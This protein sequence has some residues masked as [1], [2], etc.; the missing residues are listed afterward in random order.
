MDPAIPIAACRAGALGVVDLELATSMAAIAGVLA[1]TAEAAPAP[2][3]VRLAGYEPEL[4]AAIVADLPDAAATVIFSSGYGADLVDLLQRLKAAGKRVLLEV[5]S[6]SQATT[7]AGWGVD[8]L[9]AKGGEAGGWGSEETAFVLLQRLRRVGLPVFAQGGIGLHSVT[10]CLVAGAAGVVLDSQLL[11]TRES[12]LSRSVKQLIARLDGT[13]TVRVGGTLG[14]PCR[15]YLHV[16]CDP[17]ESLLSAERELLGIDID[18]S[19][20][21]LQWRREV[22]RHCGWEAPEKCAWMV[23]QDVAFAKSLGDRFV[24]VGGVIA[25]L[26]GAIEQHVAAVRAAYPLAEGATLAAIHGTRYPIVQGPMTRVSDRAQFALD[27]AD[28]GALPFLALALMRGDEAE[29]LLAETQALLG[30]R[31]WGVGILGF[32]PPELRK[33]QLDAI[34]GY[35]PR[36]A[37]IAGGRPDQAQALERDGIATYLHVPSTGLLRL[38]VRQGARSFVFEGHEC[39]G[40]V[41]PLS[42]FVLWNSM[43]ELLMSELP[44]NDLADCRILFAGGIHDSVSAAMVAA[45]ASP[46]AAKG[47]AIGVLMGTAYLYTREAVSSGAILQGF[48]DQAIHCSHTVLL[49]SGP[50]HATR[51]AD[52]EFART[53]QLEKQRLLREGQSAEE[54]R[55][56]LEGMNIGRLRVASK[57]IDR[58]PSYQPGSDLAKFVELEQSEQIARGMYMIGQV[59]V[60]RSEVISI[61]GLHREISVGGAREFEEALSVFDITHAEG[62]QPQPSAIAIVGMSAILPGARQLSEYWTN[63]VNNVY[64]I[65]EIPKERWDWS[66]YYDADPAAKDKIYSKWGGFIDAIEFDPVEYGMPP[67]SLRSIDPMQLIALQAA[68]DALQDAGYGSRPFDRTRTSVILGASGGIGELGGSYVLRSSLPL[69][70]GDSASEVIAAQDGA[71]PEWSEDSFAGLLPNVTAGRIANRFDFG[72][73]NYVVDAACAS[74]LA[75]VHQAVRELETGNSDTVLVGGVDTTQNPFGY[76]CFSKTRALSPTGQP[77]TFDAQGDGI[78]IGEGVVMLVLKRLADAE[79]DGDRIYAVIQGVGGASD[80]RAK[81]LTAP[82]PEGQILALERAYRKAGISPVTI[83][84]FEAHGTGTVVGDQAEA[85]SLSRFLVA[86]GAASRGVAVGSVK[87]MIGHTKATAGVAGLAKIALALHQKIL[88]PTHGVTKPNPKAG[89]GEGPLYVNSE[90]RPWVHGLAGHPRRAGVSAFGFG[91]TNFHA[92]LEEY[93]GDVCRAERTASWPSELCLLSADSREQLLAEIADLSNDLQSGQSPCLRDLSF[94]LWSKLPR[95][96]AHRAYRLAVVARSTADLEAKL[97]DVRAWLDRGESGAFE[98]PR[99]VYLRQSAAELPAQVAFLFPG[100]GSQYPNMLKDL[101]L[102]FDEVREGFERADVWLAERNPQRLSSFVFPIPAF[103]EEEKTRQQ[104][105]LKQTTVAQPAIGVAGAALFRLLARFGVVPCSVAGHSYGEYVALFA[106]GVFGEKDLVLISEARG[107][108]IVEASNGDLGTMLAVKAGGDE[109]ARAIEGCEDVWLA[110]FNAPRQ[111]IISG[112]AFGIEDARRV[113]KGQGL[114]SQ[115]IPVGCGFHSPLVA[116]ARDAFGERLSSLELSAPGVAVFSNNLAAQ[117]PTNPAEIRA[118]LR[119]HLVEPVRFTDEIVAMHDAGARVFVE[120]GPN[121]KLTGLVK[122]ILAG[123]PHTAI[124]LDLPGQ[125]GMERLQQVLGQLFIEGVPI[126]LDYLFEQRAVRLVKRADSPSQAELARR[127]ATAWRVTGGKAWPAAS[128]A[129]PMMRP[130]AVGLREGQRTDRSDRVEQSLPARA[131]SPGTTSA[132][133]S[134]TASTSRDA[135]RSQSSSPQEMPA[136]IASEH[137]AIPP[138][139]DPD[140][141]AAVMSQYQTLMGQFLETQ[142]NVMLSY[143]EGKPTASHAASP[144]RLD[145]P[146]A[147]VAP[148]GIDAPSL[149]SARSAE[150]TSVERTGPESGAGDAKEDANRGV[151]SLP[152]TSTSARA[153]GGPDEAETTARLLE[154]VSERTGYPTEMLD[155]DLDLEADLGIDSIKRVEILGSFQ[156]AFDRSD[157]GETTDLME[158]LAAAKTLREIIAKVAQQATM[159]VEQ[160]G[161]APTTPNDRAVRSD[162]A[163]PFDER[164]VSAQLLEIVSERTGYP[165][166]MLGL[167][168]DL[169]AD[170]GIDSIK[171]VEILGQF[172]QLLGDAQLGSSEGLM[173]SLA[174][175]KTLRAIMAQI[176]EKVAATGGSASLEDAPAQAPAR[177]AVGPR[178][179]N[180]SEL[181]ES[182]LEIVS[183]RT[184]YPP[185]LLDLDADLEADLGIDSIKRVEILGSIQERLEAVEFGSEEGAMEQLAAAKTLRE[186]VG[187]LMT[188]MGGVESVRG[189][190]TRAARQPAP[191]GS[192]EPEQMLAAPDRPAIGRYIFTLTEMPLKGQSEAVPIDGCILVTEDGR[193]VSDAVIADLRARG[194]QMVG[195]K[196]GREVCELEAGRFAADLRSPAAVTELVAAVRS[197]FG[198]IGGLLH[199]LPLGAPSAL[200]DLDLEHWREQ[201]GLDVKSLFYL[202]QALAADLSKADGQRHCVLAATQSGVARGDS[203]LGGASPS[204][205]GISGFMKTLALE[206]PGVRVRAIDLHPDGAVAEQAHSVLAETL[207][208]DDHV[209]VAYQ[210]G[211]RVVPV[212]RSAALPEGHSSSAPLDSSSVV[213]ITGGARGITARIACGLAASLRPTLILV[214]RSPLPDPDEA[215]RIADGDSVK[216]IKARLIAEMRGRGEQVA[217]AAVE[218]AYARLRAAR[219]IRDNFAAMQEAGAQVHYVQADVRDPARF[220]GL[221]DRIYQDFGRLDG[222]IHGAGVIEDKLIADKTPESFDRV[223]DT[224]VDSAFVLARKLRA[225]TLKLLVFFASVAGSFGNRGQAD[226]AAANEVLNQLA[227]HLDRRLPARVVAINWGPWDTAGMVSPELR[228]QFGQRGIEL[229]PPALGLEMFEREIRDG[230]KGECGVLIGGAGWREAPVEPVAALPSLPLTARASHS[231]TN[232]AFELIRELDVSR[233]LF[234]GDHRIDGKPVMPL[235]VATELM[236]E[237]V[238]LG[239]PDLVV[240]AVKDLYVLKGLVLDRDASSVRVVATPRPRLREGS[241]DVAVEIIGMDRPQRIHYRATV[242]LSDRL[243]QPPQIAAPTLGAKGLAADVA[244]LY[245]E[246]LFHGPLFQGIARVDAI[247]ASGVKAD[248]KRS[249]PQHF[250]VDPVGGDWLIDPLLFDSGL[251]LFI[252]WSRDQWD[253]TTLPSRFGSYRRFGLLSGESAYC[254]LT[255]RPETGR[256]TI[257]ADIVFRGRNGEVLGILEDAEG[258]ASKALNRLGGGNDSLRAVS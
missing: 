153:A 50:G 95:D 10:A 167:D 128:A 198:S 79:R 90:A 132:D 196:H 150:T 218:K 169:E 71:L 212:P 223:F 160:V 104:D 183:E 112:T 6:A 38:F 110:N 54:I 240:T 154:I 151:E 34:R 51:C 136:N 247:G 226:Y 107:R 111:T 49:E 141:A 161:G 166:E 149:A 48:Q 217:P 155:L 37:L 32:V 52:T 170:L 61:E 215:G 246:W 86:A 127:A 143:L 78:V 201:V 186:I 33:E 159:P 251:Q 117:Y 64:A 180:E 21:A 22:R 243:P 101:A 72:G 88:P 80:G 199:L 146:A 23:G 76:L 230:R 187:R 126:S 59:A 115:S 42:S 140:A 43:I 58:N 249:E 75:A 244:G 229:I 73:V 234:L 66:F 209:E 133:A 8:G 62:E 157:V 26:R 239:W 74:S 84:L 191:P 148:S 242:E 238:A 203:E 210:D 82:R 40:H 122:Q 53:F 189:T 1:K 232:G 41:G 228:K 30:D 222:V 211:R 177:P 29:Q 184:G 4:S 252:L 12:S 200:D 158:K 97:A 102:Y 179:L 152:S 219:E 45:M 193:G 123:R 87:S 236:A 55:R 11:L 18:A 134:P 46:L 257:H 227:Q 27:V 162:A 19:A 221:I 129:P 174:A 114:E 172:Q 119:E 36:F 245:R 91:G 125:S 224:K 195:L 93:T 220:G 25:A 65:R 256:Q 233:D 168:L 181:T 213:L 100:Q 70:L 113:L 208:D 103:A 2:F 192:V 20:K 135:I 185:E 77:R 39:G 175:A 147:S 214:G 83:D 109:T 16:G 69:V 116:R 57:G 35:R 56:Q 255:I 60:L 13:E 92:V 17:K 173:E 7:V 137:L 205:K 206:W 89:F 9:I 81:G 3:G 202:T 98:H 144:A 85:D 24:S 145:A 142:R 163:Q 28:G 253:M 258:V 176:T 237:T 31:P 14:A 105:A 156:E 15:L 99:G 139:A 188:L 254:E 248:L 5:D 190:E 44:A 63:I 121:N 68:R 197:R 47:A 130:L 118:I 120:V 106:A 94:T 182:L 131:S 194:Y 225:E 207:T 164:R 171:R 108:A 67:S 250:F 138:A 231:R 124:A 204:G 165:P 241:Q 178:T 96:G 235:A 216:D